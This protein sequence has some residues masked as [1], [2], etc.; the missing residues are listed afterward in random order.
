MANAHKLA[1]SQ[2]HALT[3]RV[4]GRTPSVGIAERAQV[5][6]PLTVWDAANAALAERLFGFGFVDQIKGSLDFL[7]LNYYGKEII[8]GTTVA[9]VDD[10]EYSEAGRAID[11]NGMYVALRAFHDRYKQDPEAKWTSYMV[12][13][14]G[15]ADSTDVLRPLYITEHLAAIAAARRDG[16]NVTAYIH[17]T[18]LSPWPSPKPMSVPT[19]LQSRST[20]APTAP[21]APLGQ[22]SDNWEWA[23]GYCPKFGL[24]AVDRAS[25]DLARSARPSAGVFAEISRARRVTTAQRQAAWEQVRAAAHPVFF[26]WGEKIFT[27]FI[28]LPAL[29][30]RLA[31]D[32]SPPAGPER[33]RPGLR[34]W[35][36]AGASCVPFAA[37][38]TVRI[39]T[40]PEGGCARL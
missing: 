29:I 15:I 32:C 14:N 37:P 26:P 27:T 1:Y 2:L 12:T 17:W 35:C 38:R 34:R 13:E 24:Y 22:T 3:R 10:E 5:V 18:V 39:A 19:Y 40:P 21:P 20:H 23:D 36:N 16:I 28:P 31:P 25:P 4:H 8:S 30:L 7:G 6:E 11:T 33:C 9:Q